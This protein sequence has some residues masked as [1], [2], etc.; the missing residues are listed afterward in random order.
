MENSPEF[1]YLN[2][3]DFLTSLK[4]AKQLPVLSP[5][6]MEL[7]RAQMTPQD[8][9][10]YYKLL[11]YFE[12]PETDKL[13]ISPELI[14][15]PNV[16]FHASQLGDVEVFEPRAE[17]QRHPT[18]P[19]LVYGSPVEAVSS[20]FL[21][22]SNDE[23][24]ASGRWSRDWPW[25]IVIGDLEKFKSLDKGAWMYQLPADSFYVD[26]NE[27]LGLFEW[28]SPAPVA[29]TERKFYPSG[30]QAMMDLGVRVYSLSPDEFVKFRQSKD[31]KEILEN[32]TPL[33]P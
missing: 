2:K 13:E 30:L 11:Y 6:E 4:E 24:T 8:F 25:T 10:Q 12:N 22:P 32:L 19:P 28:T 9:E 17:K 29:S 31:Q 5:I 23:L 7:L 21:V 18:D 1:S 15:K 3:H 14:I 33:N 26:P 20:F 16:L 27:G